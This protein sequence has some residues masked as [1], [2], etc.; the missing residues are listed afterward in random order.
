MFTSQSKAC[1]ITNSQ[2]E[3]VQLQSLPNHIEELKFGNS[4]VETDEDLHF[5]GIAAKNKILKLSWWH[6]PVEMHYVATALVQ[7]KKSDKGSSNKSKKVV[8]NNTLANGC[9]KTPSRSV[10]L[11]KYIR[12]DQEEDSEENESSVLEPNV[13]EFFPKDRLDDDSKSCTGLL[14]PDQEDQMNVCGYRRSLLRT[15]F[16]WACIFLTCG[17]LRLVLHWWRHLYLYATCSQ[18]SLEEA[19][20]VLVTE[21][22]QG[23]HKM[24]HVKQIQVL[25]SSNLKTLLE[26]EQQTRESK[27]IGCDH[28]ENLL[29]LSVHF[30]SAQFKRCSSLRIF[31]CKQL[32]YAWNTNMN[33]FQR[34][35]GLD[36][37]I[38]CSYYHQQ[39]GLTV[40]EQISRRIVFGDNEITVPLRDLKTLL[41][42]EVLNPFYVFQL[43]SVILW[44]TYDYYYYACVILLMSIF[45]ITM[46][47]LQTKKNQDVLQKT[48]YNTGNAWV[49]DHK[50]LSKELPTRAIVPG[51]IIEI[52]S[53]G[54]TLH[55]DAILLSGNCILDES[56]LTG[57]SVPVT[58]TPLPS[59]RDM[60]FDKTEHARHTLFCGTKVIQTRYIGSKKVLAFVINTGNI[61]AKGELIR[62]ILYPP[63][64][65]Y[66]FEQDSYKFIQFLAIIACVGFIYTLVTKILRGTDPVKIAVE[67]LDLITIVV[68]PALPA[69]MTV[70]RFYAQKRLKTSEIFCI[71]PRSINVA[72]SINCCCFDKTGTLTEDGLDMWGVVPK[73]STNQFQIPLQNVVRL[74]YDHFLFGMVTCHSITILNGRMMGD[75]LDL[76]MFQSTG[77]K[78]E[79]SNNIPDTEKYGILYPTILRQPRVCL[80]GMTEPE[81]KR[82]S[83]VD[84]LLATVGISP[85]Q[86]NFDH[87][88][89]REFPFTSALQRMSVVTRCLS[90]QVFNVYCKG[91]PEMLEK[92]CI[93]QSLPDN[94]SQTLSEFA[95]KG[96]RIIA[97]AFKSLAHKMNYTKVQRLSR[98]EV[99]NNLEF[100]GFVILENRLK[101]DTTKV[102]NALNSA[103]IRTIMITGDNI[104]TAISVARDCGIVSASQA[105]ITVHADPL[106]DSEIFQTNTTA[107]DTECNVDNSSH[108]HY[109]LQYT[110]DLGSKTSR[111]YLY[112]S[113]LNSNLFGQETTEFRAHDAKTI[114]RMESTNSLDNESSSSYAESVLPTSD[115]LASVKTTDTW[116]H[117]EA[118]EVDAELGIKHSE[119]ESWRQQCTFAMDGKT[120]QIVK[121]HFPE[122]KE[123]LLTRGS[124]Y[125]RMS[126]D[127]KQALVL[128]L[129]NLDY[130]VAMCGD[131]ANDCGALKVAHA[132]ISL[133][134]TEASIA[135][136]FTSRNPTISAVLRVIKEGRAALATSFG[137]FKYMAAYSL[138]QFISV[139]ILYSIDSNLTDKQYLYV[140]LGL[141]SIFAFFFGKTESFDGNL[142]EQ[143]PLSSLI[144]STPLA[145]LLLHLTVVTGFQVTCWIHLHQQPWFKP[146]KATDEDHLGCVENYTMFC[147]S[148]FQYIILAFVFSKGAPYRK[149]LWSNRPLCLA[150]IINLC[151]IVYLVYFVY[152]SD[153][154]ATFFQLIVPS[155]E[156]RYIMLAYG[157]AAFMCHIFVESFLVEYLVFK[158]YQVQREK[159]WVTSKQKYMRLEHDISKIKNWP[160]ITEVYEPNNFADWER[161]QPTYV[162]LHAEQNHDTQ[163]GKFPGFS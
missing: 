28:V 115:S 112:K 77:W 110:L 15:G 99:E 116:T 133:S 126:P 140:D 87:G 117:N 129:Q 8:N 30:N 143:V 111:E 90:D 9:S 12:P 141:I 136:P 2:N 33:S 47:V 31:R 93:P 59:K 32:V 26:K 48:V 38:P 156:F 63:P 134:E 60:I 62:S 23:K 153:W 108:K 100:L 146:F 5:P 52:P 157:A 4:D 145:S 74:P 131:G 160:P 75:P 45:G 7:P 25:N 18:C 17:L 121:D 104:L 71:S 119:D 144:S 154:V 113:S 96:Y 94:Y 34:I 44:F 37:N 84:D 155:K 152:S 159:N 21:D 132:G 106:G 125:A 24:Y 81:I 67:S 83:S 78:L 10:A 82:Q 135:S 95:K 68:P 39:R 123:I 148:S 42:L 50:G 61:T 54:C 102:I 88:I 27:H 130:C 92:L 41:F 13:D 80:S 58:K 158:K 86:K 124:I 105:V 98:E 69:A 22:Y 89:V 70:G 66:K 14:N 91:S 147:I 127:Q 1:E 49:V 43:F 72:G 161:E 162:S 122:E 120:W 137:I 85:A 114:F 76:K 35:N 20:Q 79:D 57:E 51:D 73:S 128:E 64:V 138:V 163:L 36:L 40:N 65:D 118:A 150:F 53:S 11:L 107:L 101:P 139:M 97:I 142:V 109:K 6:S 19:E 151:I 46:S 56:M 3:T 103:K 16:C 149:P 29:Q 55:C